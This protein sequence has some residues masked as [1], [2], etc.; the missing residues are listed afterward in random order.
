MRKRS[1]AFRQTKGGVGMAK[2]I[3]G[4]IVIAIVV[5]IIINLLAD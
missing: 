2:I 4:L 5:T 3:I 1:G